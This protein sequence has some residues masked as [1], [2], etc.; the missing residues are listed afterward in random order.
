MVGGVVAP[1]RLALLLLGPL[2]RLGVVLGV[3]VR[4]VDR[5]SAVSH[6]AAP[7]L[8]RLLAVRVPRP[9]EVVLLVDV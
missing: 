8:G 7:A 6:S 3:L 5:G 9:L 1:A 4:A 2:H